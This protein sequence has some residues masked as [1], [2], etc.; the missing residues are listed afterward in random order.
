MPAKESKQKNQQRQARQNNRNNRPNNN[1]NNNQGKDNNPQPAA[2]QTRQS[3]P[4]LLL[5]KLLLIM[6]RHQLPN[7]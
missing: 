4:L 7:R 5:P 2:N 6:L 3:N 1:N